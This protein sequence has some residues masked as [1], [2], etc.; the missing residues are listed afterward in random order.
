[1]A[2]VVPTPTIRMR[3]EGLFDFDGLY[4]AIIDWAKNYGYM[5][6]EKTYKHKVPTPK[7]AVQ[8]FE[9]H[10][11]KQVNDY[12]EY[13]IRMRVKTWDLTEVEVE[14]NGK[15]RVL[16]NARVKLLM[17]GDVRFDW[18]KR[19][20]TGTKF[21]RTLGRLYRSFIYSKDIE[22]IHWDTLTYR[23]WDLQ[24]VIKKY[25]DLQSKKHPYKGYLSDH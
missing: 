18:Q 23:K 9:W 16:N 6:H 14:I 7:G 22:S 10:L 17:I 5:W 11:T 13:Y 19:F 15:K 4:A 24:A 2:N 21:A 20:S 12:V 8:E 1:M 25:F 3:Y